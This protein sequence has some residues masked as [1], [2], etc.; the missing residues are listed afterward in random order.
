MNGMTRGPRRIASVCA[1]LIAWSL[2]CAACDSLIGLD[3]PTR[4]AADARADVTPL[5]R[6]NE[7]DGAPAQDGAADGV[8][9]PDDDA[10]S[11]SDARLPQAAD[12]AANPGDSGS[13]DETLPP[14]S[15]LVPIVANQYGYVPPSYPDAASNPADVSGFWYAY[16][17]GWGTTR[18]E[19]GVG[20]AKEEGACELVGGF[21]ASD[22][23]TISSPLPPVESGPPGSTVGPP[24]SGYANGFPSTLG[25]GGP[26]GQLFCLSGIA[27]IALTQDGGTAPDYS[28]IYG[29]GMGFD[30]NNPDGVKS[31]YDATA[32]DVIGVQFG[33]ISRGYFPQAL[34]V[35]F[36]T[37][38]TTAYGGAMDSYFMPATSEGT[39]RILW[40]DLKPPDP[41][42]VGSL[43]VDGGESS[44]PTFDPSHLLS[45]LFHVPT[46]DYEVVPVVT[47]CV[48]NLAVIVA[49]E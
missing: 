7:S 1:V 10:T 22:C 34:H 35:L 32:H 23:S 38:D 18:V 26:G 3:P 8:G 39:Y 27:A 2:A 4:I 33:I 28:D 45:V 31:T 42:P 17:D 41:F 25:P 5:G 6:P 13:A 30:F 46:N 37:T 19:G 36:P 20:I 11:T 14:G 9:A 40:S 21:P 49:G 47:L 29:I 16:G 24:P 15:M 44:Q 48:S 12:D 43:P